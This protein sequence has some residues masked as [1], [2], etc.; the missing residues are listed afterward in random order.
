MKISVPAVPTERGQVVRF[1][2][3]GGGVP[4]WACGSTGVVVRFNRNGYP[5]IEVATRGNRTE[6]FAYFTDRDGAT[7]QVDVLGHLIW[8]AKEGN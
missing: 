5:V 7:A 2:G 8:E 3:Y 4:R 6:E 1:V